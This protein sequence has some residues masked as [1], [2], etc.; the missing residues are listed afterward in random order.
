MFALVDVLE[1]FL[2]SWRVDA[3]SCCLLGVP[4]ERVCGGKRSAAHRPSRCTTGAP[5]A[6]AA[7]ALIY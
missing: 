2:H 5:E 7:T 4:S 6:Q 3:V 1:M